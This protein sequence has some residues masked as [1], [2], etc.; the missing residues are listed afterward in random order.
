MVFVFDKW[1]DEEVDINDIS[2]KE[3]LKQW[4]VLNDFNS[5]GALVADCEIPFPVENWATH[6]I[7]AS[8]KNAIFSLK[9]ANNFKGHFKLLRMI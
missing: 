3:K 4:L 6:G 2:K 9:H 1:F 7:K 8:L 5:F